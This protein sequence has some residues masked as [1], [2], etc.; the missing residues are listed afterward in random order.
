[1]EET[2]DRIQ[3]EELTL[4]KGLESNQG[5]RLVEQEWE[6]GRGF[7]EGCGHEGQEEAELDCTQVSRGACLPLIY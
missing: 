5:F 3:I 2:G 7:G 1:M 6:A 4:P